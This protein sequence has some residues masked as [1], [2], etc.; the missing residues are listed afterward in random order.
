VYI[1]LFVNC[2]SF[3]DEK[4]KLNKTFLKIRKNN[5]KKI[6]GR[7]RVLRVIMRLSNLSK[8]PRQWK[9]WI[10]GGVRVLYVLYTVPLRFRKMQISIKIRL[11]S[12]PTRIVP[13]S[14]QAP[15][16]PWSVDQRWAIGRSQKN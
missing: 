15:S 6:R 3:I 7:H 14:S 12:F 10:F 1:V 4:K 16:G 11:T 2:C 13:D 8:N 5:T 9:Q